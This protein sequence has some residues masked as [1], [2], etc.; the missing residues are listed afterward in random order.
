MENWKAELRI[1]MAKFAMYL[2]DDGGVF[3]D[4]HEGEIK[5]FEDFIQKQRDEAYKQGLADA[6]EREV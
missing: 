1:M 5:K 6:D 3:K 2:N 4:D